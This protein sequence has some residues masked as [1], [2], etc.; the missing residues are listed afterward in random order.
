MEFLSDKSKLIVIC[1]G[2]AHMLEYLINNGVYPSVAVLDALKLREIAPYLTPYDDIMVIIK[3][4][5]DFTMSEVYTLISDLKEF[6][7]EVKSI[8]IFSNI[9]LGDIDFTYYL[10]SGDLFH[11]EHKEVIKG[12]VVKVQAKKERDKNDKSDS[13]S[14]SAFILTYKKYNRKNVKLKIHGRNPYKDLP[15]VDALEGS[16][17]LVDIFK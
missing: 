7:K 11:G 4:L 10:Y 8:N 1:E 17:V 16:L 9:Y 5:T 14:E 15:A 3:G 2:Q 6:E 12:K 13:K